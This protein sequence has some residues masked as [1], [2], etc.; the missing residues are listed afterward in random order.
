MVSSGKNCPEPELVQIPVLVPPLI[1]P[2]NVIVSLAHMV[3]SAPGSSNISAAYSE[4]KPYRQPV[5][6]PPCTIAS[7]N[8]SVVL[9]IRCAELTGISVVLN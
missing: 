8:T 3:K 4:K 5:L 2:A 9:L 7:V 1:V 6:A